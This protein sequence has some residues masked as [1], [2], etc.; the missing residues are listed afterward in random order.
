MIAKTTAEFGENATVTTI[1][2]V[3]KD[4]AI[5]GRIVINDPNVSYDN[6]LYFS[7]NEANKIH[8]LSINQGD[9]DF[10]STSL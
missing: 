3:D 2:E 5:D 4:A 10:Y 1:F 8:V 9:D 6:T 7:I